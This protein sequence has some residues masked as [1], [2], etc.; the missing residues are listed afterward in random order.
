[1]ST[2]TTYP[3]TLTLVPWAIDT[4]IDAYPRISDQILPDLPPTGVPVLQTQQVAADHSLTFDLQPG[5]YWAVAPLTPGQRDYRYI[6]FVVTEPDQYIAGPPGQTGPSGGSG[7]PGVPGPQG[8]QGPTGA[9]GDVGPFGAQGPRGPAGGDGTSGPQGDTGPAGPVGPKGDTGDPGGP[10][11][12]AGPQGPQG[13]PGPQGPVGVRGPQGPKGDTGDQGP[14]GDTGAQGIAGAPGAAGAQGIQGVQGVK[15]D[16]GDTGA[17]GIQGVQGVPGTVPATG[18]QRRMVSNQRQ[19]S[20]AG[21][22]VVFNA[23]GAP[24]VDLTPG[25]WRVW[26]TA[27]LRASAGDVGMLGFYNETTGLSIPGVE[28]PIALVGPSPG[29]ATVCTEM[30]I[31]VA[32]NT[33]LRLVAF[34][35]TIGTT[36]LQIGEFIG[37]AVAAMVAH[38]IH[39]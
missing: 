15:G 13:A 32:A 8:P 33:R 14:K 31:T 11:G 5:A 7:P 10:V 27:F 18:Y 24:Y 38:L 9:K 6:G 23:A 3:T 22:A 28:S 17:Q 29:G 21:A 1:V 26:G 16:K 19:I 36:T 25:E 4:E 39:P 12:P 30:V 37:A 2:V 34:G 35:Q 20:A